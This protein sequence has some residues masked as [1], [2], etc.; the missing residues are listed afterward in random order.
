MLLYPFF[1]GMAIGL[2]FGVLNI[3]FTKLWRERKKVHGKHFSHRHDMDEDEI[4]ES[5]RKK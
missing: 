5:I 4:P 2:V 1:T 3:V